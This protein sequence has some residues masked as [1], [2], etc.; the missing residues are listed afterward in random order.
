MAQKIFEDHYYLDSRLG[1]DNWDFTLFQ[2]CQTHKQLKERE[3]FCQH[4]F[5]TF[6]SLGL[7]EKV[8]YL[9]QNTHI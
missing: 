9:Y 8:E 1:I 3:T 2:Q 7:N 5:K 6:Y 4:R